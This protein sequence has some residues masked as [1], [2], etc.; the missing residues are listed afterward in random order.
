GIGA[1]VAILLR[2]DESIPLW[3]LISTSAHQAN[4]AL[5]LGIATALAALTCR[6][7]APY[8]YPVDTEA[9]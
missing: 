2:A 6:L 8:Q 7:I 1:L 9:A 4:G 3:E 5:L